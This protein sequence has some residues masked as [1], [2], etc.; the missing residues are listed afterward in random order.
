MK[1]GVCGPTTFQKKTTNSAPGDPVHTFLPTQED[2][3]LQEES[4]RRSL[5]P[6]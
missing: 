5:S 3:L 4:W 6:W 2:P 1:L